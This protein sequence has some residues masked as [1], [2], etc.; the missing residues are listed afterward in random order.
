MSVLFG[1]ALLVGAALLFVIDPM[2]ARRVLPRFG[3]GSAVWTACMVF[4][5]TMLLAAYAYVHVATNRLGVRRQAALHV[6]LLLLPLW[7][8]WTNRARDAFGLS[9]PVAL[10]RDPTAE[11]IGILLTSIGLPFFVVATT[12]PLLQRWFAAL[13]HPA[14]RDPYFLY[15]MSNLGSLVGL[16]AYPLLIEP[17]LGLAAQETLWVFGYGALAILTLACAVAVGMSKRADL[18]EPADLATTADPPGPVNRLWWVTLAFVPS[19]LL[20]GV[21]TALTTDVAPLPLLWVVPLSLYLLSFVLAFAPRPPVPHALMIRALPLSVMALVPV[22]A[23]GLVQ[24]FW[25]PL[26]LLTFFAAAMVC[27][28]ELARLRPA[29]AH[30]TAFYL[31]IAVGGTLGGI[32]NALVAPLVFSRLAEY[33]LGVFLACLCAP[34]ATHGMAGGGRRREALIPLVIG[35]LTTV[36][37]RNVGGLAES[38]LGVLAVSLASGLAVLVA[39]TARSRPLRFALGVGAVLLAGG[40]AEGVDGIILHRERTFF[41]VLRV[42]E[43]GVGNGRLHRLF[44]G[45]TLHGQQFVAPDR[46]SE[47]LTYYHRSGPIGQVVEVIHSRPDRQGAPLR[48]GVVGLGAGSLAAYAMTGERWRFYEIDPAVV[49]IARDPRLFTF[50]RDSRAGSIS[51][52]TGDAR[53]RLVAAADHMFDLIVLDAF[54]SDAIPTHLLTREAVRLYQAKLAGGGLIAAH[55]SNRTVDLVPVVGQLARACGLLARVRHDRKLSPRERNDGKSPSIWAVLA[56]NRFALGALDADPRWQLPRV[57][58][59]DRVWTDDYSS[60]IGHLIFR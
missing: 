28:G 1:G 41:G 52:E 51:V 3:G 14:A 19:S 50:L 18:L 24:P 20:L 13:G 49:R 25:I 9:G 35:V 48:V 31:A 37:V 7:M 6:G 38:V 43:A 47:P 16:L 55:L 29:A 60:I 46:R 44:Q 27:H 57:E 5:Q 8:I 4:F 17:N 36:L 30:L 26:H 53:L 15:G 23:A 33:P 40:L 32:F 42:T 22:L 58:A 10:G 39:A 59:G 11:L 54:S 56:T 21:T 2:V 45:N 12:A 34:G